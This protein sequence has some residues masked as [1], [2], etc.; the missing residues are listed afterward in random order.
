MIE[1][2]PLEERLKQALDA[3]SNRLDDNALARLTKARVQAIADSG[4]RPS[5]RGFFVQTWLVPVAGLA[6]LAFAV[7]G[8]LFLFQATQSLD[9]LKMPEVSEAE[10][11][12]IL[13]ADVEVELLE[14]IDFYDWLRTLDDDG[15]S[16]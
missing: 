13:T 3:R 12:E 2:L 4:G 9:P 14:E 6:G 16:V 15:D 8:L 11:L 1:K 5:K 7:I 10:P